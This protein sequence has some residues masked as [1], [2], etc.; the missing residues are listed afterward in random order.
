MSYTGGV[1]KMKS[2]AKGAAVGE[3]TSTES[4]QATYALVKQLSDQNQMMQNMLKI[5]CWS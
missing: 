4:V 3:G 1:L 5:C 2:E